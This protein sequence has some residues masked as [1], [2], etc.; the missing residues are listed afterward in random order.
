MTGQVPS[1]PL[2]RIRNHNPSVQAILIAFV[3]LFVLFLW[4][5]FSLAQEIESL[6]REIQVKTDKLR[7]LERRQ[8]ALLKEISVASSQ[9]KLADE[10]WTLGYRPQTPVYVPITQPLQPATGDGAGSRW[11]PAA[12]VNEG[13][14]ADPSQSL[15]EIVARQPSSTRLEDMP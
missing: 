8:G 4:L 10:A 3:L 15:W 6:G 13:R 1:S 12:S 11:Q 5:N 7:A 14:P 9:Q 2:K